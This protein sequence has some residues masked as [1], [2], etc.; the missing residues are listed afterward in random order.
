MTFTLLNKTLTQ[1]HKE[2]NTDVTQIT[3]STVRVIIYWKKTNFGYW[4]SKN[5]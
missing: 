2:K 5:T 1:L 4:S 3:P